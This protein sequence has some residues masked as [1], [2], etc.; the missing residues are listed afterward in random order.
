MVGPQIALALLLVAP[1]AASGGERLPDPGL[2]LELP[3]LADLQ[4]TPVQ[5]AQVV[6]RWVEFAPEGEEDDMEEPLRTDHFIVLTNSSGGK[7]FA[8]KMEECYATI[9]ETFPFPEVEGRRLM[10]V[11]LFKTPQHYYEYYSKRANTTL[12][13]AARSKGH[14]WLDYYAT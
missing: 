12:E 8:K 11:F 9:Q 7:L 10:P 1:T 5:G 13:Q 6:A 2:T 3:A 14:A 4:R